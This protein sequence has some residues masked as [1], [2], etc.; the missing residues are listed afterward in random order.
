MDGITSPLTLI[1]SIVA[2]VLGLLLV[3][4][5]AY[6]Y[7][8]RQQPPPPAPSPSGM[9][10]NL[11][12]P[13]NDLD[14]LVRKYYKSQGYDVIPASESGTRTIELIALKDTE[15]AVVWCQAEAE[16]PDTKAIEQL[17]A[18]R[19]S[20]RATR[21]IFIAQAGFAS[22]VRQRAVQLGIE[23]RDAGQINLMRNMAEQAAHT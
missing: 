15:R 6:F 9:R 18:A 7:M 10:S 17:S 14:H 19:D 3:V 8:K 13:L 2:P 11:A 1:L 5:G 22:E 16:P 23:L 21:A 20:R 4:L 12:L